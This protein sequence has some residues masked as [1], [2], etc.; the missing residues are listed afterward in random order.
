ML[1]NFIGRFR[2]FLRWLWDQEG[3]PGFRA[4]GFAIGVFCGCF[5]LFG[6]QT[7]LG[8]TLTRIFR[9]NYLLAMTGTWVSNPFTYLPLYWL[10]YRVGS[11]FLGDAVLPNDFSQFVWSEIYNSGWIVLSRLFCGSLLVGFMSS[12][13]VGFFI[14]VVL[15]NWE[16][17]K[18]VI[19]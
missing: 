17:S 15:L 12:I 3:S 14:Y 7:L 13:F 11:Y 18:K 2:R 6:F 19:R 10:N 5:P 4:R 8:I 9:G 16:R 1:W